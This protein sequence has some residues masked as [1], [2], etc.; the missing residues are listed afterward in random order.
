MSKARVFTEEE[1][2]YIINHWGKESVYSMRK[3]FN[4]SWEAV[5]KVAEKNGLEM[6]KSNRWTK[7][8][9]ENL[10]YLAESYYYE[11]I[12]K[13]M[14][15]STTAI[16][17]KAKKMGIHL[18]QNKRSWT[19]AEEDTLS[20]LWGTMKLESLAKKM[21]RSVFSLRVKAG[22]M[23]LGPMIQNNYEVITVSD[24]SELLNVSRD[25]IVKTWVKLGL[26]LKQK[27]LT[28]NQSYYVITL[29]D[30]LKFL[31]NN[32]NEWDSRCIGRYA[33]SSEPA[34]LKEKR[35]KDNIENPLWYR[36]WSE[37][38][39]K[40]AEHLLSRGKTYAEIAL[41]LNRKEG[42]VAEVLRKRGHSYELGKFWSE[43]EINYLR[44]S[45]ENMTYA[46]IA[47]YL[48]RTEKAVSLKA[49]EIKKLT[50]SIKKD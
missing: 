49:E 30:L 15:K 47:E 20:E 26:N 38:E 36:F 45:Y 46:E 41:L 34:W 50:K 16:Y 6:P 37:E 8:E 9:E 17:L 28:D 31:K 27:K 10:K 7:E 11:E 43:E 40:K 2:N 33:L 5:C 1:T 21:K 12:A 22:R 4:C 42:A 48:N 19:K 13:I 32:Q 18:I 44:T 3:K 35:K 23:G 29:E 25:R 24:L 14:G 39:I